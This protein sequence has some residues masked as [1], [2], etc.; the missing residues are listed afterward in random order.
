MYR[1]NFER[2][3][4]IAHRHKYAFRKTV[5]RLKTR[6]NPGITGLPLVFSCG[7]YRAHTPAPATAPACHNQ[8]KSESPGPYP[9]PDRRAVRPGPRKSL[10]SC[11]PAQWS[12]AFCRLWRR[13]SGKRAGCRGGKRFRRR[14]WPGYCLISLRQIPPSGKFPSGEQRSR[15]FGAHPLLRK[16]PYRSNGPPRA[17]GCAHVFLFARQK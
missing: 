9:A 11:R 1:Q 13:C 5:I 12:R 8:Q 14:Q 6:G 4:Y 7:Q 17:R 3:G 2:F 15:Q 10:R 16:T